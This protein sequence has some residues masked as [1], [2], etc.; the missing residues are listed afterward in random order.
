MD[1]R[2]EPI[3][4]V[5]SVDADPSGRPLEQAAAPSQTLVDLAGELTY[6]TTAPLQIYGRFDR[7]AVMEY[8][9]HTDPPAEQRP[10]AIDC[11]RPFFQGLPA[12]ILGRPPYSERV[13]W[14]HRLYAIPTVRWEEC[15]EF[16]A[17]LAITDT[18]HKRYTTTSWHEL[19]IVDPLT[20]AAGRILDELPTITV[21][22]FAASA[23]DGFIYL[24]PATDPPRTRA[25]PK[26]EH[27]KPEIVQMAKAV[28]GPPPDP[29]APLRR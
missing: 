20:L 29:T 9:L 2:Q 1:E 10:F 28:F 4:G 11:D 13:V 17:R 15:R 16:I 21:V 26:R 8:V 19:Q 12:T 24:A 23:N 25:Y 14:N 7:D 22:V 27:P 18:P 6:F 5:V 3:Q